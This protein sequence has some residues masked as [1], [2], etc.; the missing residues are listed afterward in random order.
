[1]DTKP[2]TKTFPRLVMKEWPE[3]DESC[4]NTTSGEHQW[5]VC[6]I[7]PHTGGKATT[8]TP[9][10][11]A[12]GIF[13]LLCGEAQPACTAITPKALSDFTR[14][15]EEMGILDQERSQKEKSR[16]E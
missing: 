15:V 6:P 8:S 11:Y 14:V 13:C 1:M 3:R 16:D 7:D 12:S 5:A 4:R 9:Q 2:T 10:Y